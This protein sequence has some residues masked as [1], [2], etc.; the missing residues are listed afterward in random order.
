MKRILLAA[1]VAFALT[2]CGE[3]KIDGSS[4]AALKDSVDK[5][6]KGLPSDK[7]TQFREDVVALTL[8]QVS[9]A[10]VISGKKNAESVTGDARKVLDGK[11]GEQVMAQAA[12]LRLEREQR[13]RTQAL[14]EIQE[15]L[16]KKSAAESALIELKKFSVT[17]SRFE[18][19]PEKYSSRGQPQIHIAVVNSTTHPISRAYF[20]GTIA[21][22]GRSVPWFTDTFNYQ[23]PGGLEAG[24]KAEWTLLPNQFSDW[25]KIEAPADAVFTVE[26]VRLDGAD[27]KALFNSD[28]FTK[29]NE[30][31]LQQLQKK[32]SEG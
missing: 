23:I 4:D 22:P 31:R 18:I 16:A 19:V 2:G 5:V 24:E 32:Y 12:Q 26:V 6:A 11:T 20:K 3:A 27:Q 10:D 14:A 29:A 21:S 28:S 17:K 1:A 13:E 30:T 15:L 7:Q 9:L 25:G 8:S